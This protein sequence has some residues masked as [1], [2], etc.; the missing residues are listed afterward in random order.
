MT[1]EQKQETWFKAER[2][3]GEDWFI[4]L[5]PGSRIYTEKDAVKIAT[6][7]NDFIRTERRKAAQEMLDAVS[8]EMS[9]SCRSEV[10]RKG[11]E[12]LTK[13]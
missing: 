7:L 2:F 1:R 13:M 10:I 5:F 3:E 6:W 12:F 8:P 4:P 9:N 11:Q